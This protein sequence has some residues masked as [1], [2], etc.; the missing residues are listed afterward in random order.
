MV[1][2]YGR[3][4]FAKLHLGNSHLTRALHGYFSNAQLAL[5]SDA[6]QG[7]YVYSCGNVFHLSAAG[8][9]LWK[10]NVET[11]A[12]TRLAV[13]GNEVR[14]ISL[15]QGLLTVKVIIDGKLAN[16]KTAS[17]KGNAEK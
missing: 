12:W 3:K 9:E 7:V 15:E 4:Q 8:E 5:P 2:F 1:Q 14:I 6:S 17:I 13:N 11:T 10:I 16:T